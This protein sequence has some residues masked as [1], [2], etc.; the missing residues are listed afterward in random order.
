VTT[1][2]ANL[3][4]IRD[5]RE[6]QQY[7]AARASEYDRV[8][9]KPERQED[10]RAIEHWLP[11]VLRDRTVI[12]AA[13]GTGYWSNFLAPSAKRLLAIDAS[14]EVLRIARSRVEAAN[15]RFVLGDAYRL[16]VAG[17][18]FEGAFAGFWF[19][20]VPNARIGEFLHE[21]HRTLAPGAKVV[22]LDNRFVEGSSTA[23]S[24]RDADGNTY[25]LRRLEDGSTH[26]VLKNFPAARE[27]RRAVQDVAS[28]VIH[29]EWR[30]FWALEYSL[31]EP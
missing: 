15:V 9:A 3:G 8:Y 17:R 11:G 31:A 28:E 20:H 27:L 22:L 13:C 14:I 24:E 30:H 25:Q 21:L 29:H 16:P 19:S 5:A 23:I 18:E 1:A 12:E 4:D 7:Y 10:L 2:C 26:R 6:L